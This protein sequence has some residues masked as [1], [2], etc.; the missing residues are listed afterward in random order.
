MPIPVPTST[1]VSSVGTDIDRIVSG[2]TDTVSGTTDTDTDTDQDKIAPSVGADIGRTLL[3]PAGFTAPS[4]STDIDKMVSGSVIIDIDKIL[5]AGTDSDR[6][7]PTPAVAAVAG[8]ETGE[9]GAAPGA[10][11][12]VPCPVGPQRPWPDGDEDNVVVDAHAVEQVLE[13]IRVECGFLRLHGHHVLGE[14]GDRQ[15]RTTAAAASVC[16]FIR[17]LPHTKRSKWHSPLLY[18]V[19]PLLQ[20]SGRTAM[21]RKGNLFVSTAD[22]AFVKIVFANARK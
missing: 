10:G 8:A 9:C 13:L 1:T 2:A 4:V 7:S 11:T 6:T 22:K 21:V 19:A 20:R 3:V 5:N 17:G 12:L 16:V 18:S 15:C 14:E